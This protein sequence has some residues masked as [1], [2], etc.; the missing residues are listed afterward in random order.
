MKPTT[1]SI[2]S[3]GNLPGETQT[4]TIDKAAEAFIMGILTDLYSD[5]AKAVVREYSTNALDAQVEIGVTEPIRVTLPS[6]TNRNLVIADHGVGMSTE[7]I[8]RRYSAYGHST[9]RETNEQVGMIGIGCKS[10]LTYASTF[11]V[12]SIH[13]GIKTIA[14][15]SKNEFGTGQIQ[16]VDTVS[17]NERTGTTIT[18]PVSH[19]TGM[20]Q[21]CRDFFAH[22]EPG[23]VLVD[24]AAPAVHI[25][26]SWFSNDEGTVFISAYGDAEDTLVMGNVPYKFSR[27]TYNLTDHSVSVIVK[28]PIGSVSFTPSREEL[29]DNAHTRA[30][31]KG[32]KAEID[33]IIN[34][35]RT[36]GLESCLT[37]KDAFTQAD[38]LRS[39]I[40]TRSEITYRGEKVPNRQQLIG[41][42]DGE[43][44]QIDRTK[45]TYGRDMM[46][47]NHQW[48]QGA[49]LV[50]NYPMSRTLT[51]EEKDWFR[52]NIMPVE[53]ANDENR[54]YR[55]A[56]IVF[57]GDPQGADK[58][59]PSVDW[60]DIKGNL[61]KRAKSAG[62]GTGTQR[63]WN[64]CK[65]LNSYAS[66]STPVSGPG[67]Y[68]MVTRDDDPADWHVKQAEALGYKIVLVYKRS[69]KAFAD[70]HSPITLAQL[71]TLWQGRLSKIPLPAWKAWISV[72]ANSD[73]TVL[74]KS[75]DERFQA[76]VDL[77]KT[78]SKEDEAIAS[79]FPRTSSL[80]WKVTGERGYDVAKTEQWIAKEYP[81]IRYIHDNKQMIEY[82]NALYT[83][84]NMKGSK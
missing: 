82:V 27:Y 73:I 8:L 3:H 35:I 37:Y 59:V 38:L 72:T 77:A 66:P 52:A 40:G 9:K 54:Y 32:V 14:I 64:D 13:N 12:E 34:K 48:Q 49:T 18:I 44:K 15:V 7:M 5:P 11:T 29:M 51:S 2:N 19:V 57:C 80:Y 16:V 58:W 70:E 39:V 33:K 17:T 30:Y 74:A 67:K 83:Y 55:Y 28:A 63:T 53:A 81:M 71:E 6:S 4:M 62:T 69:M 75:L 68:V 42:V 79:T 31:M 65:I 46:T 25:K 56:G 20:I 22:W 1:E 10:G 61:P 50:I 76:V 41:M 45:S 43:A 21:T 84:R 23:T 47:R 60:A 36:E 26:D 24:G 78:L